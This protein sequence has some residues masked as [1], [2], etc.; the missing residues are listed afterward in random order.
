MRRPRP[1]PEGELAAVAVQE[2]GRDQPP[3]HTAAIG[4][5]TAEIDPGEGSLL[6]RHLGA[7]ERREQLAEVRIVADEERATR[8]ACVGED[9]VDGGAVK[10]GRKPLG[11]SL[12]LGA[13]RAIGV[14]PGPR[15]GVP[16]IGLAQEVQL[17]G[18]PVGAHPSSLARK[19][20]IRPRRSAMADRYTTSCSS[21][22]PV[23]RAG[24][25]M[26][27]WVR[28]AGPGKTGQASAALSQTVIT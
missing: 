23:A 18:G 4:D 17:E 21:S 24:S 28:M 5:A 22:A 16:G 15:L 3:Q 13:E 9:G 25:G 8:R 1:A 12:A 7:D 19:S 26:L 10:A 27:Q 14:V 11:L 2:V 6:Q 20:A